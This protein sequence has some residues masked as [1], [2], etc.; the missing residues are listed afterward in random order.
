M[1]AAYTGASVGVTG[2]TVPRSGMVDSKMTVGGRI[3]SSAKYA[4]K[5]VVGGTPK[6][7]ETFFAQVRQREA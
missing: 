4:L 2:V 6:L 5:V 1:L 7:W 3:S